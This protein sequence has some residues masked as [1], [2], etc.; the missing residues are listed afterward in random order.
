[1]YIFTALSTNPYIFEFNLEMPCDFIMLPDNELIS[2]QGDTSSGIPSGMPG[3]TPGGMPSGNESVFLASNIDQE[4]NNI[5]TR[6]RSSSDPLPLNKNTSLFNTSIPS[7]SRIL[8]WLTNNTGLAIANSQGLDTSSI[9]PPNSVGVGVSSESV[10]S[11]SSFL[12]N[13]SITSSVRELIS[14]V[15]VRDLS[16]ISNSQSSGNSSATSITIH[17]I[18]TGTT[19]RNFLENTH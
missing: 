14:N 10:S 5:R 13:S 1:M 12:S 16:T 11:E 3:G 4:D 18:S 7:S 2:Y 15:N 19:M 17:S 9:S 8:T 6:S